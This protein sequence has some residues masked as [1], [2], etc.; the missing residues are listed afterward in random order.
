M[1]V[2][3]SRSGRSGRL[4]SQLALES[5]WFLLQVMCS[6]LCQLSPWPLAQVPR[7]QLMEMVPARLA[8]DAEPARVVRLAFQAALNFAADFHVLKLDLMGD[9]DA[10][11]DELP[12]GGTVLVGEVLCIVRT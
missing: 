12:C 2:V 7:Q 11:F 4:R 9:G 5:R 8:F 6:V 1:A 10:A 3:F